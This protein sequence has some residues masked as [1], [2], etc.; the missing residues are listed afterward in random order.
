VY[1]KTHQSNADDPGISHSKPKMARKGHIWAP[2]WI[3]TLKRQGEIT[4]REA[5]AL[6]L[7][8]DETQGW[9][10]P[11]VQMT[12][13]QW[14]KLLGKSE[15]QACKVRDSLVDKQLVRRFDDFDGPPGYGLVEPDARDRLDEIAKAARPPLRKVGG[16]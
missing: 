9:K 15:R 14:G 8:S 5:V 13:K 16:S 10:R 11:F 6:L 1:M 4:D 7:L 12:R 2:R 3:G